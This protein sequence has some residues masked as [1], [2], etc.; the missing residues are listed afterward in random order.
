VKMVRELQPDLLT[1]DVHLASASPSDSWDGFGV[2]NWLR[3]FNPGK[4]LPRIV[5]ISAL[6]PNAIIEHAAAIGAQ[7]FLPKPFT[8]ERL[9]EVVADALK[10]GVGVPADCH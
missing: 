7:T 8:K 9:L 3:R 1:L 5:V 4:S 6:E 2:V 10:S